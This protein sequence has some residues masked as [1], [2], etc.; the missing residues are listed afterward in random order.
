M[1]A[2]LD[3]LPTHTAAGLDAVWSRLATGR[4]AATPS[5]RRS[6]VFL[7][8]DGGA[9]GPEQEPDQVPIPE[10]SSLAARLQHLRHARLP[11]FQP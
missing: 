3:L 2:P 6:V 8:V 10:T 4:R 5:P 11:R 7:D 1:S 9:A